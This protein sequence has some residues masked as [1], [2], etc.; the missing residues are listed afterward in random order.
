MLLPG[1][2]LIAERSRAQGYIGNVSYRKIRISTLA[3]KK[4]EGKHLMFR[5]YIDNNENQSSLVDNG[6]E[7]EFLNESFAHEKGIK[8][9]ELAGKYRVELI[10]GRWDSISNAR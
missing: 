1:S 3:V 7:A 10:L 4:V 6:S 2:E 9:F 5:S 8:T